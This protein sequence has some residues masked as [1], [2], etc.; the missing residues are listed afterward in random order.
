M[1]LSPTAIQWGTE[2]GSFILDSNIT[3]SSICIVARLKGGK[4]TNKE[5]WQIT[6]LEAFYWPRL[7]LLGIT[8]HE[9]HK[10]G[11]SQLA[12]EDG[13]D[14]QV[15]CLGIS[16]DLLM[17]F[18]TLSI[19]EHINMGKGYNGFIYSSTALVQAIIIPCLDLGQISLQSVSLIFC[20]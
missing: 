6:H 5:T 13:K 10:L 3:H 8:L 16:G 11:F 14:S 15:M 20:F 9:L 4:Q 18:V 2:R 17:L 19:T 1:V 7:E 12:R